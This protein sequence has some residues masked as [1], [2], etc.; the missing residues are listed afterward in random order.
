MHEIAATSIRSAA[1][2]PA[3]VHER[4]TARR[5]D[6]RLRTVSPLLGVEPLCSRSIDR[7]AIVRQQNTQPPTAKS[8]TLLG[9]A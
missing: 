9:I 4:P 6:L 7:N 3:V 5:L 8:P 1:R 2:L